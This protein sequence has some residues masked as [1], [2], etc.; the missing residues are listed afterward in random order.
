MRSTRLDLAVSGLVAFVVLGPLLVGPGYWLFGDM[1]FVPRQ[2]WKDA[3]LGLDG[4]LPRAVPMDAI[5]S[6]LTH[7]VPGSWVQKT[8]LVTAFVLGG[9]GAARLVRP[10]AGLAAARAA[11][12]VLYLWNPWVHERLLLG[13]WAIL[14]GY[15]ALPW[16]ALAARRLRRDLRA[17]WAPAAVALAVSAVCSPSSGVMAVVVLV[18]LGVRWRDPRSWAVVV[19]LGVVANLT[20]LLPSLTADAAAVTTDGVFDLFAARAE[21]A[22]GVLASLLSLG[23]TWKTSILAPE[24]TSAVVVL[25]SCLLA[26]AALAGLRRA[27]RRG[28]DPSEVRRLLALAGVALVVAALPTSLTGGAGAALLEQVGDRVPAAALLRDSQRFLAP[29]ALALA[30]GLAAAVTWVR[31]Q[32]APGREAW[33]AV[34]GLAVVAPVVLLP[35]LAW[36]GGELARSSYPRDW[37]AVADLVGDP[38]GPGDAATVVLPWQ[39]S[40]RRFAFNDGRAV[41]DPAPRLLP[42][43]VLVDDRTLVDGREVP[44]EDPRVTAVTGALAAGSPTEVSSALRDLGVRWVLVEPGADRAAAALPA[45]GTAYDGDT[46]LLLDLAAPA[47]GSKDPA[48]VRTDGPSSHDDHAGLVIVGHGCVFVLLLCGLMRILHS[49]VTTITSSRRWPLKS[50]GGD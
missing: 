10:Y 7:L 18:V 43:E 15:L 40:Y 22:A 9:L 41:L 32:V 28:S 5:V 48:Q 39:G 23:G 50:L 46:L 45:G 6:V 31:E 25:L 17:G 42:G 11:A 36:G 44:S 13:Q 16:V 1:V 30:V 19:A 8:F 3:W 14:A 34:V 38:T 47:T 24:R 12:T 4:S 33:W 35:S 21:S 2:P 26:A 49:G 37:A 20:W 27:L 29:A